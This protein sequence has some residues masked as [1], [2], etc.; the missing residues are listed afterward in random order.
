[1]HKNFVIVVY[2]YFTNATLCSL[3][4]LLSLLIQSFAF[5]LVP[6]GDAIKNAVHKVIDNEQVHILCVFRQSLCCVGLKVPDT[7]NSVVFV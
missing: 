5:R 3:V 4:L 6:Y 1:M 2:T 7:F